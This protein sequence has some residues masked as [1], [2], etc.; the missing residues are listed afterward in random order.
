MRLLA[1]CLRHIS[2][3]ACESRQTR[4]T[5][6]RQACTLHSHVMNR[7]RPE[8]C[9]TVPLRAIG[10][11]A[12]PL[13]IR[14]HDAAETFTPAEVFGRLSP[15]RRVEAESEE[16]QNP[17]CKAWMKWRAKPNLDPSARVRRHLR[18]RA[19]IYAANIPASSSA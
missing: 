10:L 19:K 1:G 13:K 5:G 3:D 6:E 16:S 4:P 18:L 12:K 17:R 2:M 9:C 8:R 11:A 7:E 15:P 14:A